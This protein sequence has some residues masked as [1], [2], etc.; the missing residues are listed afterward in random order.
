MTTIKLIINDKVRLWFNYQHWDLNNIEIK[1]DQSWV[2]LESGEIFYKWQAE[3]ENKL[4][5]FESQVQ[6]EPP[7][8]VYNDSRTAP[9]FIH[10]G[11]KLIKEIEY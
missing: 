10:Q 8:I 6:L 2:F 9:A 4:K 5:L 7:H 1:K 3:G 11:E